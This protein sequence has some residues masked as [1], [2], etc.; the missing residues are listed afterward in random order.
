M[1]RKQGIFDYSEEPSCIFRASIVTL[2]VPMRLPD[3]RAIP[4]GTRVLD[5]HIW[6]EH[7]P[8]PGGATSLA[9]GRTIARHIDGSLGLLA[10]FLRSRPDLDDIA[11]AR[12]LMRLAAAE[13]R[14]MLLNLAGRFGFLP[15]QQQRQTRLQRLHA[16]GTNFLITMLMF[17]SR[18][19]QNGLRTLRRDAADVFLPC[20]VLHRRYP[21]DPGIAGL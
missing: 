20:D 7:M 4:A 18:M 19:R 3:A 12:A 9:Y 16:L 6:N 2:D 13:E 11:G 15:I 14:R 8:R 21:P 5:L 10:R 1:R 17:A